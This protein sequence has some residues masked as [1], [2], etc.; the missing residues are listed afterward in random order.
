MVLVVDCGGQTGIAGVVSWSR[1]R[2]PFYMAVDRWSPVK[3]KKEDA[4][5]DDDDDD[6]GF[7]LNDAI[8]VY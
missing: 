5:D 6:I 4:D 3:T 1:G 7:S 2:G 8:P